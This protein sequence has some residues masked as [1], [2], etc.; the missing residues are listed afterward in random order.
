MRE[1]G[2]DRGRIEY[3]FSRRGDEREDGEDEIQSFKSR[4]I[5]LNIA[6]Q[7]KRPTSPDILSNPKLDACCATSLTA[8]A[9]ATKQ[10]K[11]KCQTHLAKP[12]ARQ[13]QHSLSHTLF[14]LLIIF[15]I[16]L[17]SEIV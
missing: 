16:T 11:P 7:R 6:I 9:T 5:C 3:R 14:I 13:P 15:T 10:R 1:D 8:K 4:E 12:L 17:I 2:E